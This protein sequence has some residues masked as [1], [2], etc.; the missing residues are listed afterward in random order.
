M[1]QYTRI[2]HIMILFFI[3]TFPI[4][5][6]GQFRDQFSIK[7]RG[8]DKSTLGRNK[9]QPQCVARVFVK[10]LK[11]ILNFLRII[12]REKNITCQQFQI[13]NRFICLQ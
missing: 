3:F 4:E 5:K 12:K 9:N 10:K 2:I 8:P 7:Y 1:L 11:S 6:N 13:D